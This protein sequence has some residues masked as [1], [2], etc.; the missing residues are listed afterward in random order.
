MYIAT[1]IL[2]GS[3][4]MVIFSYF[5]AVISDTENKEMNRA[6]RWLYLLSIVFMTTSLGFFIGNLLMFYPAVIATIFIIPGLAI[7]LSRLI[8]VKDNEV[9]IIQNVIC[10]QEVENG[11][12]LRLF[13][14]SGL[15][16]LLHGETLRELLRQET[17]KVVFFVNNMETEDSTPVN[18]KIVFWISPNFSLIQNML[19]ID[20]NQDVWWTRVIEIAQSAITA[21]VSDLIRNTRQ[22]TAVTSKEEMS[23]QLT[24][25]KIDG[26]FLFEQE[27]EMGFKIDNIKFVDI[28]LTADVRAAYEQITKGEAYGAAANKMALATGVDLDT[29]KDK[30]EKNRMVQYFLSRVLASA[31]KVKVNEFDFKNSGGQPLSEAQ[32]YLASHQ[33]EK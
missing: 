30:E 1:I 6:P 17:K 2:V 32:A 31:G 21:R 9:Q 10:T 22:Q 8:Q 11:D 5:L 18:V 4:L 23:R 27:K 15:V 26:T 29:I 28:D 24:K 19:T 16:P 13:C 12:S 7:S 25:N 3:S 33:S 20:Q 14:R